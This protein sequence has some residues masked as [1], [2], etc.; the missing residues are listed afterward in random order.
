MYNKRRVV[1][2]IY[3][4]KQNRLVSKDARPWK[5]LGFLDYD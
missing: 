5:P 4:I 3:N 1:P 2:T